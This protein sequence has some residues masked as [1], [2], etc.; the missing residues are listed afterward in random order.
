MDYI[1]TEFFN[2]KSKSSKTEISTSNNVKKNK[3]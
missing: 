2:K 1:E 3:H